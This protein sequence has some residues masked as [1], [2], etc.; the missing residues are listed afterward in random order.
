LGV[1]VPSALVVAS[2]SACWMVAGVAAMIDPSDR[3]I[4]TV[5]R[6]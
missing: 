4:F 6:P 1:I 2:A 3:L 5:G